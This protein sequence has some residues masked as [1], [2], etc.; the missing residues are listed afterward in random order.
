MKI[1]ILL[2][3]IIL[4]CVFTGQGFASQ[5]PDMPPCSFSG[6]VKE[7]S[8]RR[9]PGRGLSEGETF[10]Y[11]DIKIEPT[12][13]ALSKIENTPVGCPALDNGLMT[14]QMNSSMLRKY[15]LS[16]PKKGDCIKGF[17]LFSADGNFMSG[18]WLT[19]EETLPAADCR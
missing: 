12:E 9:E 10:I 1:L 4:N 17:S 18:N 16:L 13:G 7:V 5:S 19:V 14:V 3:V 11:I 2:T 15:T 8:T 6:E